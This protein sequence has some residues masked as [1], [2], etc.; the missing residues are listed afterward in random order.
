MLDFKKSGNIAR[1]PSNPDYVNFLN[2]WTDFIKSSRQNPATLEGLGH[3]PIE[4]VA[5][6]HGYP[7]VESFGQPDGSQ[8]GLHLRMS[9][10]RYVLNLGRI[11]GRL[12]LVPSQ[13]AFNVKTAGV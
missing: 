1:T 7:N 12:N 9:Q 8:K 11:N 10:R 2:N 4:S 6:G 13:I 3:T 5:I